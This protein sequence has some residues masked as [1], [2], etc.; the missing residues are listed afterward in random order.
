[1]HIMC[2]TGKNSLHDWLADG[3]I[4]II[5]THFEQALKAYSGIVMIMREPRC[6]P[7][8]HNFFSL[9]PVYTFMI[10]PAAAIHSCGSI[11][12]PLHIIW[13]SRGE[14][15]LLLLL[16]GKMTIELWVVMMGTTKLLYLVPCLLGYNVSLTTTIQSTA[17]AHTHSNS[18]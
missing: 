6:M 16:L 17:H 11:I 13:K 18:L 14:K 2:L 12:F 15:L 8:K 7:S 5:I 9:S 4:I 1:M 3:A 10:V